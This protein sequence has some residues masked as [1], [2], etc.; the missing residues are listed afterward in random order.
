VISSSK[1]LVIVLLSKWTS[2]RFCSSTLNA[3]KAT[4]IIQ[5]GFWMNKRCFLK[6]KGAIVWFRLIKLVCDLKFKIFGHFL[7]YFWTSKRF[8]AF[9]FSAFKATKIAQISCEMSKI[10]YYEMKGVIIWF[11][12]IKSVYN[13]KL[14]ILNHCYV[15]LNFNFFCSSTLN[16]FKVTNIAQIGFEWTRYVFMKWR[17]SLLGLS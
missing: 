13:L 9:T 8:C 7:C 10:C 5:I 16:A 12:L 1:S 11:R 14:K 3:F 4:K 15:I 2:K 6:V 17:G